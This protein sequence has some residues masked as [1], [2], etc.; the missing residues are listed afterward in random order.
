VEE[1][2]V[3]QRAFEDSLA[4]GRPLRPEPFSFVNRE[5]PRLFEAARSTG[6][7]EALE[8]DLL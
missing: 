3:S 8:R 7:V 2:E 5:S 4:A 6:G 1:L